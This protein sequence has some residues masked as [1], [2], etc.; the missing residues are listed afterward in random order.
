[1]ADFTYSP[2]YEKQIDTTQ[3]KKISSDFV[4]TKI[5]D[6]EEF[7]IVDVKALELI[8]EMAFVDVSHLLRSSHLEKLAH[9]LAAPDA[10]N[11]DRFVAMDLLRNAVIA[12]QMEFPSCQDT[13]TAIVVGKKVQTFGLW[14]LKWPVIGYGLYHLAKQVGI[15]MDKVG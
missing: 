15:L 5:I 1:M 12:A 13:G 14:L 9:I 10:S 11:N 7:L 6:G 8:S 2:L 4:N 3:Y